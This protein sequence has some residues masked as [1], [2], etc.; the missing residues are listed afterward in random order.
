MAAAQG[1]N[2]AV[3]RIIEYFNKRSLDL[4]DG[5]F[6]RRTQFVINGAPFETLLGRPPGDP[7]I[8]MLARGPAGYRFAIKALQHAMPDASTRRT[9]SSTESISL[10]ASATNEFVFQLRLAGKLRGTGEAVDIIVPITLKLGPAG[11]VE[12]AEAT[13]DDAVLDKIRQA[14]LIA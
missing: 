11:Q 6:D 5:V 1:L 4:P 7:L 8:L 13:I 12:T 10:S 3:D 2:G 9:P 14:R